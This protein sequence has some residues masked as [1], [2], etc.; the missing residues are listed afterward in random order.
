MRQI[1]SIEDREQ[2]ER[3][4]AYLVSLGISCSVDTGNS[5]HIV[6]V[7]EEDRVAQA[8]EELAQF[9]NESD[10]ER[11]RNATRKAAAVV[12]AKIQQ[13][14][15][16]RRRTIDLR[17]RWAKP[18][19]EHGPATFGMMALMVIVAVLTGLEPAKHEEFTL[20]LLFS[21]DGTLSAIW[22]GEVWRLVSPVFLHT[23]I[24]HFLFNLIAL[25][26]LGLLV[27]YRLGTPKFSGMVLVIAV[28]SNAAQFAMSGTG[29]G[30]MSGVNYGLFGYIWVRSRLDP[31][32]G[33][34]LNSTTITYMLG[35]YVLCFVGLVPNVAN[36]AHAGGL[37]VGAAMG[38]SKPLLKHLFGR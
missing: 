15:A 21:N 38:A 4:A 3:F 32:S 18:T 25:R 31:E 26:D 36:W 27:E 11:Y 29:F 35:W 1:G 2:V 28:L 9:R 12:E 30:G 13:A 5:G 37:M 14:V 10:H 34:G 19:I 7:H 33:F 24:L 8:K 6:W 20:R 16:T 22:S 17:D 23:R